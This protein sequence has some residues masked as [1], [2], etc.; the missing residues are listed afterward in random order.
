MIITMQKIAELSGVSLATVSKAFS[1]SEEISEETRNKIFSIAKKY[2]CFEKYNKRKTLKKVVAII[3]P[4]LSS[5]YY[6]NTVSYLEKQLNKINVLSVISV[7]NFKPEKEQELIGY[8]LSDKSV[9]GIIVLEAFSKIK[10]NND[11][12]IVV[13]NSINDLKDVDC[14]NT[15]FQSAIDDA[16]YLLKRN[17]HEKIAFVGESLTQDKYEFFVNSMRKHNLRVIPE[18]RIISQ[19]RFESAGFEAMETLYKMKERPTAIFAAYDYIALGIIQSIR[20]HGENVPDDY[21]VIGIDDI[22]FASQYDIS[23]TSIKSNIDEICDTAIELIMKKINNK[24]Y[25]LRQN[26]SFR[27]ELKI[28][29][30]VKSI[31]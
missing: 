22:S 14:I 1:G 3:C 6:S 8:Y 5:D 4:E 20:A 26:I 16:I 10:Y 28:R 19:N 12:P 13:I 18:F 9:D 2:N 25:R 17:G 29:N 11:T 23:L 7:S 21:S 15:D 31:L 27:G 24:F 30:S